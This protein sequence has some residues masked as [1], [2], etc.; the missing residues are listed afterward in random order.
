M[1]KFPVQNSGRAILY[2]LHRILT[3]NGVP[4]VVVS[5]LLNM[6]LRQLTTSCGPEQNNN[7][8]E[9]HDPAAK[10]RPGYCSSGGGERASDRDKPAGVSALEGV[11]GQQ[12]HQGHGRLTKGVRPLPTTCWAAPQSWV[13]HCRT[14]KGMV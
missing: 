2:H 6:W 9:C 14:K 3:Q 5:A 13:R 12:R 4:L 7:N 11:R 8:S 1:T 10:M